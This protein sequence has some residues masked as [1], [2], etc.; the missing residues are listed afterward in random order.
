MPRL[1]RSTV[2]ADSTMGEPD[3]ADG[4]RHV[5][6]YT[7]FRR[8]LPPTPLPMPPTLGTSI[9]LAM[10]GYVEGG[11]PPPG[12]SHYLAM[13]GYVRRGVAMGKIDIGDFIVEVKNAA[14]LFQAF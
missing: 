12:T 6:A 9:H 2:F 10:P 13:P 8:S 14:S 7:S 11:G 3:A 1:L 5:S 4:D